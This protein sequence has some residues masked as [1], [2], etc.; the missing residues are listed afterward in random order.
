VITLLFVQLA[1]VAALQTAAA[2]KV[3]LV[4]FKRMV[5]LKHMLTAAMADAHYVSTK[6]S[7]VLEFAMQLAEDLTLEQ[8]I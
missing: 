5:Q 6:I 1:Q 4:T 8:A 3:F 2:R 7:T